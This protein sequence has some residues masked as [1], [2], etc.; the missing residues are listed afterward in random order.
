MSYSTIGV[1]E[2]CGRGMPMPQ[3][4]PPEEMQFPMILIE[5]KKPNNELRIAPP[6]IC[7]EE[8][9]DA[10]NTKLALHLVN[11][12]VLEVERDL[13]TDKLKLINKFHNA[14]A[15]YTKY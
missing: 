5:G 10:D 1:D 9:L 2:P 8:Q 12:E 15:F 7:I 13:N 11:G 4:M 14:E 3:M 6:M